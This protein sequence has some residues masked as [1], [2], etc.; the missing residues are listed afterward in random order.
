MTRARRLLAGAIGALTLVA[1]AASV[2][3][4]RRTAVDL[5]FLAPDISPSWNRS[6][7]ANAVLLGMAGLVLVRRRPESLPAWALLAGGV[8]AAAAAFGAEWAVVVAV[9]RQPFAGGALGWWAAGWTHHIELFIAPAVLWVSGSR[10]AARLSAGAIAV[11]LAGLA[12]RPAPYLGER[13]TGALGRLGNPLPGGGVDL[14]AFP[15]VALVAGAALAA[16]AAA[17][18]RQPVLALLAVAGAVSVVAR[19]SFVLLDLARGALAVAV[20]GFRRRGRMP[21]HHHD[22]R[23]EA[24]VRAQRAAVAGS[25]GGR[26]PPE[27]PM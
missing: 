25:G 1:A 5:T 9:D 11:G 6:W 17:R 2:L 26:M 14:G 18:A 27:R 20:V 4:E 15:T 24:G 7:P 22:E 21:Q 12:L 19:P 8:G 23:R 16:I 13:A 3:V 10:L